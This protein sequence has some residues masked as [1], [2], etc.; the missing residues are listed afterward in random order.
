MKPV[1][2]WFRQ[3]LRVADHRAL[4]AAIATG[5]P[6]IPL[7]ILDDDAPGVWAMGGASR[8]WLNR[9]L[10]SL[11]QTLQVLGS[12]LIL[13]SGKTRAVLEELTT[14]VGASDVMFQA[15]HEP[16]AQALE[17][18]VH[19]G[20]SGRGVAVT[21]FAGGL[22]KRPDSLRTKGGDPYKVYTPFWRALAA[23][24]P[25][26]YPVPGPTSIS[27]PKAWP[28]TESLK[29]WGLHP[30]KPDWSAGFAAD[31]V[32][33]ETGARARLDAFLADPVR[34]YDSDRNR[35]DKVGTSRLSPHLHFG[36][37]SPATC[38]F[39]SKDAA[40]RM[41]VH[42]SAVGAFDKGIET[43]QKELVWREFSA[44]LIVHWPTLPEAPFKPAYAA[45]PW[46]DDAAGFT[47]WKRGLTGFPIVDAGMRELWHTGWMHNRVRMIVASFLIKDL[48]I[49][50][51]AGEAWFWDTLVDADLASNAA[52]WQW[53]AGCGADAAP[54]FRIFNPT[55]QGEA[56]DPDGSYVRR[57]VPELSK[58][59]TTFIHDPARAPP[60]VLAAAGVTL[61]RTYPHAIVDHAKARDRALAALAA[62][63]PDAVHDI[64]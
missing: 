61:G 46:R 53:V 15:A 45:F 35:P 42:N 41:S 29:S 5:Q 18:D 58:V 24:E 50:W 14:R 20:L 34:T 12:R 13:R 10:G 30:T 23:S 28:A 9:S 33:G 52:S 16:W 25:P 54:Y 40:A 64:A 21:R 48:L 62:I 4:C 19:S 57:W 38:W 59:P 2:V 49:P 27:A 17:A 7:Y 37:I 44:H 32:P 26:P 55:R 6:V 60:L 63:K 11:A 47:A 22:L 3:D 51:Q 43:F 31:W 1:V 8:W 36:E 39:A 56:Y